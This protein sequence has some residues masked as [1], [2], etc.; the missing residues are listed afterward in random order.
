[1][2]PE[3]FGHS[4][5]DKATSFYEDNGL[6]ASIDTVWLQWLFSVMIGL[7][8]RVGLRTNMVNMVV[9]VCQP[10]PI[11]GRHYTPSHGRQMDSEGD[12]H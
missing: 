5:T 8:E 10:V 3:G 6:V 7:F 9:M 4:V 1:M 2:D 11:I 12:Y